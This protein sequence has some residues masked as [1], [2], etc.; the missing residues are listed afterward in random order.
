MSRVKISLQR[1]AR[2]CH[3]ASNAAETFSLLD[4]YYRAA[5]I[6]CNFRDYDRSY[7]DNELMAGS[8]E[9]MLYP[10]TPIG[11]VSIRLRFGNYKSV[12]PV[13]GIDV[14]KGKKPVV[15]GYLVRRNLACYDF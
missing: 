4:T 3:S 12:T 7:I 8:L 5:G 6:K 10:V 14:E 13:D 15:L 9:C 1:P 11:D 2:P